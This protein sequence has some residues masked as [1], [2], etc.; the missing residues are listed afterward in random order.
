MPPYKVLCT[1][2]IA[3]GLV[4]EAN[5]QSIRIIIKEFIV[6]TPVISHDTFNKIQELV[7]AGV[8]HLVFTSAN[9]GEIF[10]NYC[11][12]QQIV[13]PEHLKVFCLAG[14]T[15]DSLY[16]CFKD[17]AIAG[18]T[19]N[20]SA[21]AEMILSMN[22]G[23]VLFCCG[24][25]RRNELPDLLKNQG[26]EVN[27]VFLYETTEVPFAVMN[28][29]DLDAVM[30]FSPSAVSSFFSLNKMKAGAVCFAIGSTTASAIKKYTGNTIITSA[31]PDEKIMMTSVLDYFQHINQ[32]KE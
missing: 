5:E 15:R 2:K 20:A 7:H 19:A 27:E 30:F 26:I 9:A 12:Q 21:L 17:T 8:E 3:P 25:K 13:F 24:N 16:P 1:K 31:V 14:K 32:H 6:I 29:E 18:T 11:S 22:V 23:R 28:P 10:C 4:Q